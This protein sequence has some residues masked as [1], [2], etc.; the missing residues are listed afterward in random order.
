LAS[1][2]RIR[3]NLDAIAAWWVAKGDPIKGNKDSGAFFGIAVPVDFQR[4]APLDAAA[5]GI[6]G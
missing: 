3:L 2:I 1:R 5:R 6:H 4:A